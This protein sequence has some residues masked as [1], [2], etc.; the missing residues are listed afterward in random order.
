[1]FESF[2]LSM[3]KVYQNLHYK[4]FSKTAD[5]DRF[6]LSARQVV[7]VLSSVQYCSIELHKVSYSY[8]GFIFKSNFPLVG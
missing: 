2:L 4:K 5:L 1:M 6:L 8:S 3:A 7:A